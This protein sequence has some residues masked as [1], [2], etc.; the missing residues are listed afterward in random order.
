MIMI[1]LTRQIQEGFTEEGGSESPL[2]GRMGPREQLEPR[3]RHGLK[4][5]HLGKR[6]GTGKARTEGCECS[7]GGVGKGCKKK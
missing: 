2:T 5:A 4:K 1:Q 3:H 6:K 7:R